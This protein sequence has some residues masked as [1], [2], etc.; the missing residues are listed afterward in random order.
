MWKI[1]SYCVIIFWG[2]S[3]AATSYADCSS[4][5]N[6]CK[7]ILIDA[8]WLGRGSKEE[9]VILV[10]TSGAEINLRCT[11]FKEHWLVLSNAHPQ[12]TE[13]YSI[14]HTAL[15]STQKVTLFLEKDSNPCKISTVGVKRLKLTSDKPSSSAEGP[16]GEPLK[17]STEGRT[18]LL[19]TGTSHSMLVCVDGDSSSVVLYVDDKESGSISSDSCV[20]VEGSEIVVKNTS[21]NASSRGTFQ[22]WSKK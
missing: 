6:A 3:L 19:K 17:W 14:L 1:L 8:L 7:D 16:L 2:I 11:P 12:K 22:I 21:Y 13:I 18:F 9:N 4:E 5:N 10:G 15:L 20:M